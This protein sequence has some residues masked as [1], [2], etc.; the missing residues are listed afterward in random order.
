MHDRSQEMAFALDVV[1]GVLATWAARPSRSSASVRAR[2][3]RSCVT[4]S[5]PASRIT[6]CSGRS[7]GPGKRS[8]TT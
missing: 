8:L 2:R 5:P 3:K 4:C 6:V 7:R 1:E